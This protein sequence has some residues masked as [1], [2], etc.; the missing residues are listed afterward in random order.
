MLGRA[1]HF[2]LGA[3]GQAGPAHLVDILKKD[4]ESNMGQ[5]GAA[6]LG[7]LPTPIMLDPDAAQQV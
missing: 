4:M 6:A 7:A 2:A 1:F 3:L 5:I